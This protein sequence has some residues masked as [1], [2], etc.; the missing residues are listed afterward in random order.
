[1]E[2]NE[3]KN[4]WMVLEEQLKKNGT[5]NRQIIQEML[6]KKSNKSLKRLINVDLLSAIVL[7]L[8]IPVCVWL[9]DISCFGNILSLKIITIVCII[10]CIV[11]IIWYCY[12]LKCLLKINFSNSIKDNMYS[13]NKYTIMVRQEKIA[14]YILMAILSPLAIYLYYEFKASFSLWTFLVVCLT[15]GTAL[16]YWIYKRF[17]NTNLQIIKKS[18]DEMKELEEE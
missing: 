11:G 16:I 1:M 9:L 3:L 2:L 10:I 15:V 12:K 8:I 13:V 4:R 5:L 7:A 14:N 6:Y 17:Y 18:L